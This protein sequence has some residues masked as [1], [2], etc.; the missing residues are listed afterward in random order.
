[1]PAT[2]GA[3][4]HSNGFTFVCSERPHGPEKDHRDNKIGR[5]GEWLGAT[6]PVEE[7]HV[8]S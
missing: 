3:V 8:R 6:W 7:D 4:L 1:M 5:S 2:C